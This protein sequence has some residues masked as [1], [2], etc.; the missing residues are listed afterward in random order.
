MALIYGADQDR[1]EGAGHTV[2]GIVREDGQD[3][4]VL[5]I[6]AEADPSAT[7][8]CWSATTQGIQGYIDRISVQPVAGFTPDNTFT[9]TITDAYGS[10]WSYAG[11]PTTGNTNILA[12]NNRR[13]I[14]IHG[15]LT[16]DI[17]DMGARDRV[18]ITLY[19]IA[20]ART[21]I[22]AESPTRSAAI[23]I[24]YPEAGDA[25]SFYHAG[26]AITVTRIFGETDTGTVNLNMEQRLPD[27][28]FASGTQIESTALVADADGQEQTS[29]FENP[30]VP[31]DSVVTLVVASVASSPGK[32]IAGIEYTV[33]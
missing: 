7:A 22:I 2:W 18:V 33:D 15:P 19:I 13:D 16:L 3:P 24:E 14:P 29:G 10:S 17:D 26:Q 25:L 20:E 31:A 12:A 9:L 27:G 21:A 11:I 5:P 1:T 23:Y 30:S 6:T 28:Y 4:S 32:L 8:P